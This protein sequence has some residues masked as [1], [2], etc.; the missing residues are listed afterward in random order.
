MEGREN[1]PFSKK[2][3]I[4]I[5]VLWFVWSILMSVVFYA[6]ENRIVWN[7]ARKEILDQANT[8]AGRLPAL[9]EN[10]FYAK[11]GAAKAQ[12]NKLKALSLALEDKEDVEAA[13]ELLDEFTRINKAEELVMYDRTGKVLYRT[14]ESQQ[15]DLSQET[16]QKLLS[17]DTFETMDERLVW[18]DRYRDIMFSS[19]FVNNDL[20]NVFSWNAHGGEWTLVVRDAPTDVEKEAAEYF[21]WRTVVRKITIGKNGCLL[22]LDASDGT[23][24]SWKDR[25]AEGQPFEALEIRIN[26]N[27]PTGT[28]DLKNAFTGEDRTTEIRI[29][30]E[31]YLAARVDEP[32]LLMLELIPIGEIQEK[33][34]SSAG[35]LTLLMMFITGICA[36]YAFF[37]IKDKE[38][39]VWKK[40]KGFDW[41][42]NL[43]SKLKVITIVA[44]ALV[45]LGGLYLEALSVYA[46]TF[47]YSRGKVTRVVDLLEKNQATVD[48]LQ[49]WYDEEYVTRCKLVRSILEHTEKEKMTREFL[50]KLCECLEIRTISVY[51]AGGKRTDSNSL[52]KRTVIPA[53]SPAAV[54]LEG[55]E[56]FVGARE[57]DEISGETLQTIGVPLWNQDET[58]GGMIL[59][60][61]DS[62]ELERIRANLGF[63]SV[64]E[65]I[66]L[67]DGTF[68]LVID[69][70][71][72]MVK[73]VGEVEN[74]IFKNS[75]NGYDYTG[76]RASDMGINENLL[77]DHYNGEMFVLKNRY[78]ASARRVGDY[79]F[80][81]MRPPVTV[82]D[83]HMT[84]IILSVVGTL[85]Y[86]CLLFLVSTRGRKTERVSTEDSPEA[87]EDVNPVS[88]GEEEKKHR[89]DDVLV[90]LNSIVNKKKPYFEERWPEDSVR[91]KD[92]TPEEKFIFFLKISIILVLAALLLHAM[93]SGENSV[94][95]YCI[96]GEWNSGINLYSI[97]TCVIDITLL[98]VIKMVLHKLLYWIARA[99]RAKGETICHLL[100]SFSAY[101]LAITG[102]FLCLANFGVDLTTLSLTG[103]VLGV[104]FGIGCQHIV[105]DILAG[106]LMTFEGVVHVGDF[107]SYNGQYGVILSIGVRTTQLVWFSETTV[108][109][110]NDFKNYINMPSEK[111]D[112]VTTSL[113]VDLS[114]S[115]ERVESILEEELPLIHDKLCEISG[116][117]VGGPKYRGV[118]KITET[119]FV[120]SFAIYCKGMYYGWLQRQLNRELKMMC[121]R[122]GIRIGMSQIFIQGTE[123]KK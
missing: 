4:G 110:N 123:E 98:L 68:V 50:D 75:L 15:L 80:L 77:L 23:I 45:F 66:S 2:R 119:S 59:I 55:R 96:S 57:K 25:K 79:Y 36:G 5:I 115:I 91:W 26:G 49:Q 64:F 34:F 112:R 14:G 72:L 52:R 31:T 88:D 58:I 100:N 33:A 89:D 17:P 83:N 10:H 117:E 106:I 19:A 120:L 102:I 22:A 114:E 24:L 87:P 7:E 86:M 99:V 53:D 9:G 18:N 60:E 69:D 8:I 48:K 51:D 54:L 56:S 76:L 78:F 74:G 67:T 3:R 121:E 1:G 62:N 108:V 82:A 16:I 95:Y 94:W 39:T 46:A 44:M 65:Q 111:T 29:G 92:R 90:M 38:E 118:S 97:T 85:V 43:A 12:F 63:E 40:K 122:R 30:S 113:F 61:A 37:H 84:P 6:I 32:Y 11:V 27:V 47:S 73:Y 103:G 101:L 81:V 105:A 28:E 107:V 116:S 70:K 20:Q 41:D 93:I 35:T 71:E 109:R 104:I 21:D 13:R 42:H